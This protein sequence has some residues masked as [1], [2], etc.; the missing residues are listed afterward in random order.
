[1]PR[2]SIPDSPQS[3]KLTFPIS[4]STCHFAHQST[5]KSHCQLHLDHKS[6]SSSYCR[7]QL[8]SVRP[9]RV[10]VVDGNF[11][12][13]SI[14]TVVLID[15]AIETDQVHRCGSRRTPWLPWRAW[16]CRHLRRARCHRRRSHLIAKVLPYLLLQH[17][18]MMMVMSGRTGRAVAGAI[19]VVD[20]GKHHHRHRRQ[21]RHRHRHRRR[22]QPRHHR[23]CPSPSGRRFADR[24][25]LRPAIERQRCWR[26]RAS[27]LAVRRGCPLVRSRSRSS[28]QQR[29]R[30]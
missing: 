20:N 1:M 12:H 29:S 26:C 8:C 17:H 10:H 3:L 28:L 13:M 15:F 14:A 6:T 4:G 2:R 5:L 9:L 24:R 19:G 18:A 7:L 27:R 11:G 23:R 21:P 30:S 16:R 22:W 25:C